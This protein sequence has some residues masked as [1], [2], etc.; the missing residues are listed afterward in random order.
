MLLVITQ[1]QF[2][3]VI[4]TEVNLR[5]IEEM[6]LIHCLPLYGLSFYLFMVLF[7]RWLGRIVLENLFCLINF[8][9][10]LVTKVY[11]L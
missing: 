3:L 5:S 6:L 4:H 1:H 9:L 11:L 7:I 8:S 2:L 10:F